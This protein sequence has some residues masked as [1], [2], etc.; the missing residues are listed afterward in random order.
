[1]DFRTQLSSEVQSSL[2]EKEVSFSAYDADELRLVLEQ[3]EQVAFQDTVLEDGVIAMC[4]E[5]GAK[6]SGDARKAL[7]LLLEAGDVAR[8]SG[9]DIVTESYV[10]EAR[11]RVQ[12]DQVVEGI[13][14]YSQHGKLVLYA[15]TRLH[16]RGDTPVRTREV[17][18]RTGPSRTQKG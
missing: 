1:M 3:G 15:L 14:N 12:T 7:D 17:V 6:D 4:A 16:E 10:Q 2:C 13:Q 9:S 5:Y 11:E 8:E 18:R